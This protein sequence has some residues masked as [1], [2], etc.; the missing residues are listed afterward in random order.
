MRSIIS[1][2]FVGK[3]Q[4]N[5]VSQKGGGTCFSGTCSTLPA[6]LTHSMLTLYILGL[7]KISQEFDN[8]GGL[9][10]SHRRMKEG[11]FRAGEHPNHA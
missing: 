5:I 1:T 10:H 6:K 7:L 4:G 2:Y 11:M 9:D 8:L 3:R